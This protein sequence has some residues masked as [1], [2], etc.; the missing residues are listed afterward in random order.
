[1][2][3]LQHVAVTGGTGFVGR[4]LVSALSEQRVNV[5][6]LSRR[7]G[8]SHDSV[9]CDLQTL[10]IPDAAF[11]GIDTVFHLAGYAHDLRDAREVEP[12]YRRL[13]VEASIRLAEMAAKS[14]VQRFIFVSSVKAGGSARAGGCA[15][16]QDQGAPEGIY[17][18]TKREA[19]IQL[20]EIGKQSEMEVVI[21]RPTLVYGPNVKG[22]LRSM[23]LAVGRGLFPPLPDTANRRSMIH[24]DDLVRVLQLV[25]EDERC[26]GEIYI[27]ADGV[28]Y[29]T[30][31]LYDAMRTAMNRRPMSLSVPMLLFTFAAK[32]GDLVG[33]W[34][35]FDSYKLNKLLG[36]DCY[37]AAKL[38]GLGFKPQHTLFSSMPAV[39]ESLHVET[40]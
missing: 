1:V 26:S 30:R 17:G 34:F 10:N 14:G 29:S 33:N 12:L 9:L 3:P 31:A 22:N 35:P 39:V 18:M 4:R 6:L 24:V 2:N 21:V 16:E 7:E 15:S 8:Q 19:E 40:D 28:N 5:R 38:F 11:D 20:L 36:D 27:A 25:A 13:N 37:S 32:L 23:I